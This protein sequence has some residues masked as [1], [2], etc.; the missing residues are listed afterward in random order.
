MYN[1][2]KKTYSQAEKEQINFLRGVR[3]FSQLTDDQLFV[4]VPYL[5]PRKYRKDEAVF[6]H[7]DPSQAVYIMKSGVVS[8]SL[9]RNGSFEELDQASDKECFGDNAF[10]QDTHRLYNAIVVSEEAD[11]IVLP[12]GNVKDIF[13]SYPKI[14]ASVLENLLSRYNGYTYSL[15]KAYKESYG[16][17]E[18][19]QAYS[20]YD[21]SERKHD[22]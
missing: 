20:D 13:E 12:Q 11:I 10:I 18:L 6:F 16:F 2:F 17:F 21:H 8:L 1:P 19:K 7:K 3:P 9:E 14:K 5:Y 22:I 4:F 15:F